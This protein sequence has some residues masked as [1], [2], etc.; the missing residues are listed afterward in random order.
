MATETIMCI[1]TSTLGEIG[2]FAETPFLGSSSLSIKT[3]NVW[4]LPRNLA[5]K[6]PNYLQIIPYIILLEGNRVVTYRR[7]KAGTEKRLHALRSV[8]FGGHVA[9]KDVQLDGSDQIMPAETMRHCA[10][11]E[12]KE[13]IKGLKVLGK[14]FLGYIYDTSNDVSR[15]HL[16]VV[17]AWQVDA[18]L[19][20]SNE[21]QISDIQKATYDELRSKMSAYELWSQ[22]VLNSICSS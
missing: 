16:G 14:R 13:E 2:N 18:E 21:A 22:H 20:Q 11:R 15:V 12:L 3:E 17:E 6:D 1:Q 5:E 19:V 10:E 9:L 4:F 7:S 8:G